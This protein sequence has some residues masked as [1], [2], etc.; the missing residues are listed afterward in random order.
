MLVVDKRI[1]I[2]KIKEI[3]FCDS[4]FEASDCDSVT[5]VRCKNKV[6]ADGFTR[7]ERYTSV[8]DLSQSTDEIWG[9]ASRGN[10]RKPINRAERAGV[11]IKLNQYY[12]EFYEMY[13]SVRK[14]KAVSGFSLSLED[15]QRTATL[16]VAEYKGEII[17]G[18]GYVEDGDNM[19]SW[20]IGSR[21]FEED[22]ERITLVGNASKL[23]I[24]EAIKYAKERGIKELD[25]GELWAEEEAERDEL[26]HNIN[27]FKQSF[28]GVTVKRYTYRKDYSMLAK[29]ARHLYQL[30]N[31]VLK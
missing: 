20:V 4:P 12:D 31:R 27:F 28:G 19:S 22:K 29:T 24:W 7:H 9:N 21:R 14:E 16:F 8:I 6:D 15:I 2:L 17:S 10:C 3:H 30:S 18:H 23:I 5:F 1:L 11:K 25:M 26:K 13:R